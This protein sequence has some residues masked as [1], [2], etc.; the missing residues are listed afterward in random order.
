MMVDMVALKLLLFYLRN[1]AEASL[2]HPICG[3]SSTQG[4]RNLDTQNVK[5]RRVELAPIDYGFSREG[6]HAITLLYYFEQRQSFERLY[7]S[8]A[9]TLDRFYPLK[10]RLTAEADH[11]WSIVESTESPLGAAKFVESELQTM[12]DLD[13]LAAIQKLAVSVDTRMGSS[14]AAFA[15]IHLPVGSLLS[16]SLNHGAVD[17][18]AYFFFLMSWA[19]E[20]RGTRL[21]DPNHE[22]ALLNFGTHSIREA[23]ARDILQES[24]AVALPA[25]RFD[26][27]LERVRYE[28]L[29]L[30]NAFVKT[31]TEQA[32]RELGT[33][34]SRNDVLTAWL[35][36]RC[37]AQWN[38]PGDKLSV[39]CAVDARR[40]LEELTPLYFGNA[41]FAATVRL[42]YDEVISSSVATLAA[43]IRSSVESIDRATLESD[44]R[45]WEA[46]RARGWYEND[47]PLS[48]RAWHPDTGILVTNMTRI[49]LEQVDFG[50]GVPA[51]LY[52]VGARRVVVM[53]SCSH[54]YRVLIGHPA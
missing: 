4:E 48:S 28:Q 44:L 52:A 6:S 20:N 25:T 32:S 1:Q 15:L 31:E 43:Q 39:I 19:A 26:A 13:D 50:G 51:Q 45:R 42:S 21:P 54:G 30:T 47:N 18:Y 49:P 23:S 35:W 53:M 46:L 34:L 22:R 29:T 41:S 27:R 3:G 16:V 33:K 8:L 11:R 2:Q 36:K 10:G 5:G 40:W 14:L 38:H 12:P 24:Q 37:T 17:G 9:T 7:A